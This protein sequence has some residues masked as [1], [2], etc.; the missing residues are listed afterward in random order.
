MSCDWRAL[1]AVATIARRSAA[2]IGTRYPSDLPT[3]V[4]AWTS[5][6]T[7]ASRASATA[8]AMRRWTA[9]SV[10]PGRAA[11]AA[12]RSMART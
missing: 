11:K 2:T 9:R 12:S 10:R 6:G 8:A 7:W 3:P 5:S 4:G 1:V